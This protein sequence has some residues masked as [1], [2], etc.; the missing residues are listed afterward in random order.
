MILILRLHKNYFDQIAKCF[1]KS[2]KNI[3]KRKILNYKWIFYI[4]FVIYRSL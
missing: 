3:M 2:Y 1:P 4:F